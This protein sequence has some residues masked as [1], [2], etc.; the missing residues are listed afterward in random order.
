MQF[1]KIAN[2][3]HYFDYIRVLLVLVLIMSALFSY[4]IYFLNK[5]DL[6][7]QAR[8]EA[9]HIAN[10]IEKIFTGTQQFMIYIGRQIAASPDQ[11]PNK[12]AILIGRNSEEISSA[13]NIPYWEYLGCLGWIG[14]NHQLEY[15]SSLGTLNKPIDMTHRSYLKLTTQTPWELHLSVPSIGAGQGLWQ[16]PGGMGITNNVGEYLGTLAVGFNISTINAYLSKIASSSQISFIV[17]DDHFKVILQSPDNAIDPKTSFFFK[18]NTKI[19]NILANTEKNLETPIKYKEIQYIYF[20]KTTP[21]SY[22][23]LTGFN[24]EIINKLFWEQLL[25]RII[26]LV[27]IAI[28][29]LAALYFFQQKLIKTAKA[30]ERAKQDFLYHIKQRVNTSVNCILDHTQVL[31]SYYK[32]KI[33]IEISSEK[34]SILIDNIYDAAKSLK[35]FTYKSLEFS[36]IDPNKA[37]K[38]CI[39]MLAHSAIIADITIKESL[40]KNIPPLCADELKFKQVIASFIAVSMDYTAQGGII[41]ISTRIKDNNGSLWLVI[42]FQDNG[43]SLSQND[44]ERIRNKFSTLDNKHLIDGIDLNFSDIEKLVKMHHGTYQ[45]DPQRGQGKVIKL[46]FP[47]LPNQPIACPNDFNKD[48][49]KELPEKNKNILPFKKLSG[50]KKL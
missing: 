24:K 13:Y 21:H 25:E 14:L 7:H 49:A 32:G 33:D 16:I 9:H 45:I 36:M 10:E 5:K 40:G 15:S 28:S 44:I 3:T 42:I 35:S 17:I 11:D 27:V 20:L 6:Q 41:K 12:M 23:I 31:H 22:Y 30:S 26:W 48:E 37:I 43:F 2:L 47:Y 4:F 8:V 29:C 39:N 18:E 38:E 1:K 34:L 19:K 46:A 50:F